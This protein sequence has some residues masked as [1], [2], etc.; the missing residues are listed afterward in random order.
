MTQQSLL[1]RRGL[2]QG[3]ALAAAATTAIPRAMAAEPPR[4]LAEE[5]WAQKGEVR[6]YLYRKRLEGEERRPVLFLVHGSSFSGRGGFD[7]QVPGH[8][9]YSFMDEFAALGFDVWTVD[10]ENYGRSSRTGSNSDVR[11]GAADLA[12]VFPV[13]EQVTGTRALMVYAQSSGALR[14]GVYAMEAPDRFDRLVLDAFTYTGEGAPEIMRRRE[15]AATYRAQPYRPMNRDSFT[16]IF[17]RDD[18]STFE[19]A[20]AQALADYELALGDRAPSGTYL[21]MAVNMPLVDPARITCPVLMTRAATDG[22]ATDAELFEFFSKLPN[23][24]RQFA[25]MQGVAHIAVLGIN[26]HRIWHVMHEF[27]T[28]PALRVA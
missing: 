14:A 6:L 16:G 26:R 18:P 12:A 1:A 24:D 3:A 27:F 23:K 22:N 7:L 8:P 20:M 11:S 19:P 28:Y 21:D 4:I 9:G 15:Q 25:M 5:R 2:I 13:V 10:H 17:S